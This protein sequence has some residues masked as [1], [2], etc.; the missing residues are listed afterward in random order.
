MMIRRFTGWH[1]LAIMLSFFGLVIMVN[2]VMASNAIATFGGVVVSNS[3][4]AS[5]RYNGWLKAAADQKALGWHAT[6]SVDATGRLHI[7]ARDAAGQPLNARIVVT[8]RHPLGRMPDRRVVLV[9]KGADYIASD[10]LPSGRWLLHIE[11]TANGH[12]AHFED[13]VQS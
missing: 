13:E 1:M 4:V 7:A 11:L 10:G 12:R 5:Q 2:L 6:P 3:Y 8:A 9:R